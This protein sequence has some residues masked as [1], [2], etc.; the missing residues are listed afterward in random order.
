MW[1]TQWPGMFSYYCVG[2]NH[3]TKVITPSG[4]KMLF[5]GVI[6]I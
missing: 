1:L 2:F 3:Q 6:N 5:V 4:I